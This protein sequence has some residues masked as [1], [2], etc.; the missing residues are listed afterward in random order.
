MGF[1]FQISLLIP[2]LA[3][4]VLYLRPDFVLQPHQSEQ[5]TKVVED[6]K[7]QAFGWIHQKRPTNELARGR[8]H[9]K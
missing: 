4:G 2:L 7:S 5:L 1:L 3:V 8:F 6:L 9:L